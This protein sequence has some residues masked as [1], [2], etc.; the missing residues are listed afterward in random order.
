MG[1]FKRKKWRCFC[2]LRRPFGNLEFGLEKLHLRDGEFVSVD[3]LLKKKVGGSHSLK[4]KK[5]EE[6]KK[7]A[8]AIRS[9]NW[10]GIK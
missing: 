8:C 9:K 10:L 2:Y 3:I 1:S 4:K 5:W 6:K 7:N